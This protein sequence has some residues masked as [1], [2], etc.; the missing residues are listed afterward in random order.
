MKSLNDSMMKVIDSRQH[1]N[2]ENSQ[3]I[4]KRVISRW[5]DSKAKTLS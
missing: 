4:Y 3:S 2:V 5:G 1:T